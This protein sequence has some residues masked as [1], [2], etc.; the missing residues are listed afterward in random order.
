MLIKELFQAFPRAGRVEWLGL[1]PERRGPI[2]VVNSVEA[3]ETTGLAGDHYAG[4]NGKRHVTLIQ[5]EHLPA[6]AAYLGRDTVYPAELRRNIV[7]SGFNLLTLKEQ[8][9]QLGEVVLEY[10]GECHPC[11]RME[12]ALGPGG[13]NAVRGH[14]GI[15][16]RVV[17][18]GLIQIGDVLRVIQQ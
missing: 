14:G 1:R 2:C 16:A 18:G 17:R 8:T 4:L 9:F 3:S 15:T 13:Y 10:T 6:I 12:V 7:I 5:A 11:T